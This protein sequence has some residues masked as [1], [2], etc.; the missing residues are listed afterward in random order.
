MAH[1]Y[2]DRLTKRTE[3][4]PLIFAEKLGFTGKP[5]GKT[6]R[7]GVPRRRVAPKFGSS[8]AG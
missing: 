2:E 3:Q 8:R 6:R 5:K 1:W 4:M 7:T